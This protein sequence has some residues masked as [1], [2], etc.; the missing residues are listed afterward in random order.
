MTQNTP[1]A[2]PS[3]DFIM[4]QIAAQEAEKREDRHRLITK[5]FSDMFP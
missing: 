4:A 1:I 2:T 3:Y 5:L